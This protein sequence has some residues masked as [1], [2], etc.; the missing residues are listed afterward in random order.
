[1]NIPATIEKFRKEWE[2][3]KLVKQ[4]QRSW[5][6]RARLQVAGEMLLRAQTCINQHKMDFVTEEPLRIAAVLLAAEVVE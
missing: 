3:Q 2:R 5:G 4:Y 6:E 1:M